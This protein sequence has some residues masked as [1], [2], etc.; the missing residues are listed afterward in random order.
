MNKGISE[1]SSDFIDDTVRFW[2]RRLGRTISEEDAREMIQNVVG[3]FRVLNEW[4]LRTR[5]HM[6]F[7]IA[8]HDSMFWVP[9]ERPITTVAWI[10]M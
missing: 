9:Y 4:D 8:F 7:L 1:R 10:L 5:G 2:E 6:R 3:V